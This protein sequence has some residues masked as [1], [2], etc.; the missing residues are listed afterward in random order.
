M[1]FNSVAFLFVFLPAVL[2]CYFILPARFRGLRNLVLLAASLC[3]YAWGGLKGLCIFLAS[4][5]LNYIFGLGLGVLRK[6]SRRL[7]FILAVAANL[8]LLGFIRISIRSFFCLQ[9]AK[10]KR[11]QAVCS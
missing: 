2:L 7:L 3:F 8:G 4:L 9:S 5:L 10:H 6:K 1:A 11:H